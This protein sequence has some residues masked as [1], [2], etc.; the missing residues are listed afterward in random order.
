MTR[1]REMLVTF[2]IIAGV[3]AL[4]TA[5]M[6]FPEET[7]FVC[8]RIIGCIAVYVLYRTVCAVFDENKGPQDD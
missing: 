4:I 3:T 2:L 6:Y 5:V 1:W 8:F 7:A